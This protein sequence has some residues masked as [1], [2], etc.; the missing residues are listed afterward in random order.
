[1]KLIQILIKQINNKKNNYRILENL[2]KL[3]DN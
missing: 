2:L 3:K 1:M